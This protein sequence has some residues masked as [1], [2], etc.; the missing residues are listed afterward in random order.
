MLVFI[1]CIIYQLPLKDFIRK[2][3]AAGRGIGIASDYPV[4]SQGGSEE[5]TIFLHSPFPIGAA[6]W[7]ESAIG[8]ILGRYYY[9]EEAYEKVPP[10]LWTII[11]PPVSFPR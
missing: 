5:N 1:R 11:D 8:S 3:I 6:D 2:G 7:S 10:S 4:T 9:L